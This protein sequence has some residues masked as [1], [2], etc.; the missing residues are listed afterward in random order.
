MAEIAIIGAGPYGLSIAAH[1]K[2]HGVRFRIFGKAM[3]AWLA[4]MPKGMRLKSEGFA[5]GLYDPDATFTLAKYCE[6]K[7]I[8]YRD[9]GLP[10]P[11]EVFSAYGLEFQKSFVQEL[12]EKCVASVT[13]SASGF[14]LCLDDGEVVAA[15]KII[16]ALGLNGF[17]YVPPI[18]SALGEQWVTHSSRHHHLDCF[19]G[20]EVVVV[21]AGSSALELAALL[22]RVGASVRLIARARSIDFHSPPGPKPRPLLTRIRLPTTGLGPGRWRSAFFTAAP[23]IFRHMPLRFRRRLVQTHVRPAPAWFVRDDVIGKV[24]FHLGAR[25]LDAEVRDGRIRLRL[26]DRAGK[27]EVLTADHVIA[28]TGF[29]VDLDR[30]RII[31]AELRAEIRCVEQSPVLS[32]NFESSVP[33]LY[34]VGPIAALSFGPLMRF[35]FGAQYAATRLSKH[36]ARDEILQEGNRR[37]DAHLGDLG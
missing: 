15:R 9:I 12:E 10:T 28:A 31:E 14:Q 25:I 32:E 17:E 22:H 20:R 1:L 5:S 13:R 7:G 21:G 11:L 18:L 37:C 35:A 33:G 34:F 2:S 29:T 30:L 3:H 27:G 26:E 24:P 36:L 6:R 4:Q 19:K 23:Q 8:P 16:I